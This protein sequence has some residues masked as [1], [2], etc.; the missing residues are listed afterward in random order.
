MGKYITFNNNFTSGEVSPKFQ[1]RT[2]TQQ[3]ATSARKIQNMFVMP[4][5]GIVRRPGSQYVATITA[6]TDP[7]MM[8]YIYSKTEAYV[9]LIRGDNTNTTFI[10][11]YRNN[12]TAATI[13]IDA[14]L[15]VVSSALDRTGWQF[16]TSGPY[17]FITHNSGT[18]PPIF[19]KRRAIDSFFI[20][21]FGS[22][23]ITYA[24][25]V[26]F[27]NGTQVPYLDTNI[28]GEKRLKSSATTGVTTLTAENSAAAPI[29][30]FTTNHVG[31]FFKLTIGGTTG[32]ILVTAYTNAS[33]VTG[34]ILPLNGSD[35]GGTTATDNWEESAWSNERGWPRSVTLHEQRLI[36]G[37]TTYQPDTCYCSLVGNPF[38]FMQR[39]LA[40]DSAS[41]TSGI[42]YFGAITETDPFNFTPSSA[43]VNPIQWLSSG[44]DLNIGTLGGEMTAS[45]GSDRILSNQSIQLKFQT[46]TGSSPIQPV[47][48]NK[49]LYFAN[50]SSTKLMQF[51][52]DF[53]AGAYDAK[54]MNLVAEHI[55]RSFF[56]ENSNFLNQCTIAQITFQSDR[57]L[58]WV[59]TARGT[60]VSFTINPAAQVIGW[61]SHYIGGGSTPVAGMDTREVMAKINSAQ[62]IPSSDGR[63]DELW[64]IA[65]RTINAATVYHLEKLGPDFDHPN[66][67]DYLTPESVPVLT[68]SS[69][70]F[71]PGAP[72]SIV[73]GLAHLN[74]ESVR[75]VMDGKILGSYTVAA[76]QIDITPYSITVSAI[77]G[78]K[79][80]PKLYL[81]RPDSGGDFGTAQGVISRIDRLTARFYKSYGVKFG[82]VTKILGDEPTDDTYSEEV[83]EDIPMNQ[84]GSL[85]SND[86]KLF[87]G[88]KR[89][90]VSASP[91]EPERETV[92]VFRQD[93]PAPWT[94]LGV[95]IR[96]VAYD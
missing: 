60:L 82:T 86:I 47:R 14:T 83:V 30:F 64:F 49:E 59:V 52:Y 22:I 26:N 10:Q 95:S 63:W 92:I 72:T 44:T 67:Y 93:D 91:D 54:D 20:T 46:A 75:V 34:T 6:M 25:V 8:R 50:R 56:T 32:I 73:T 31:A 17:I 55:Y 53:D 24:P 81:Q 33:T 11:I 90:L 15:P 2:D 29:T 16:A 45:G 37:G 9:I 58:I 77:V 78:L 65:K 51:Q 28:D 18:Y 89:L 70:I 87:T 94:L 39:R 40:Q 48:I 42:G 27:V 96:G 35:L 1:G 85:L 36:F 84:P 88:D 43:E 5:G 12:G 80:I 68:D 13:N 62:C 41:N 79:Y 61:Q 21:Y 74:G 66:F 3:F 19:I 38:F 23:S 7:F 71:R 76:G 4:S 57:S 69:V